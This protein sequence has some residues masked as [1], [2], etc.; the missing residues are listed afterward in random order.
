LHALPLSPLLHAF[1]TVAAMPN[2]RPEKRL[3]TT[4]VRL[5]DATLD[6]LRAVAAKEN[7]TV[8]NLIDTIIKEWL[9]ARQAKG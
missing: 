2:T 5:S 9:E 3:N 1:G 7:R 6:A 4:N 8:S